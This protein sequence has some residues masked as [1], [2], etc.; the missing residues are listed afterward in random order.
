MKKIITILVFTFFCMQ[1]YAQCFKTISTGESHTIA[2]KTNGTFG[3]GGKMI[4][5]NLAMVQLF[6][7]VYQLK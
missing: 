5:I 1:S 7:K 2:I 6:L 3:L 4:K